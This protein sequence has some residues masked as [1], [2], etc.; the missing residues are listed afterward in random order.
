MG[1][2]RWR[3]R[4]RFEIGD[5]MKDPLCGIQSV[6]EVL[7]DV[8]GRGKRERRSPRGLLEDSDNGR[9]R[10]YRVRT[11]TN[12]ERLNRALAE[13]KPAA[14]KVHTLIWKW[15]GAPARGNLPFFTVH[16]LARF[17]ALSRPTVRAGLA[18]LTGKGWIQRLP[19]NPH[20]KNTL[21]RLVPIR[22][23]P[24]PGKTPLTNR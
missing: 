16:S 3:G 24:A 8:L 19:Y 12:S 23:V 11:P 2:W 21:Y 9:G 1:V 6:G 4:V 15:C 7:S 14:F 5:S 13:L 17:C 20:H 22:K 18:E 10:E